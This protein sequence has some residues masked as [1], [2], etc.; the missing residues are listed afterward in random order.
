MTF[1]LHLNYVYEKILLFNNNDMCIPN[2][3]VQ[4]NV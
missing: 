2:G 1:N 3:V 4:N